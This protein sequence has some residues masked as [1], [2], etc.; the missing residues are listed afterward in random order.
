M[1]PRSAWRFTTAGWLLFVLSAV[2]FCVSSARAGEWL[3]FA[4]SLVFLIACFAFLVPAWR[5]RPGPDA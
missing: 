3:G 5:L 1:T 2:L 4:A